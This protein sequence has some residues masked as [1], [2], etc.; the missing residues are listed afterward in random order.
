[1]TGSSGLLQES[2]PVSAGS[3]NASA[4]IRRRRVL[5]T[6]LRVSSG[7]S[8]LPL[9]PFAIARPAR[10]AAARQ[11]PAQPLAAKP[12]GWLSGHIAQCW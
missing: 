3:L 5:N 11:G 4:L 10:P 9:M 6:I 1:M 8:K 12:G 2:S 7:G